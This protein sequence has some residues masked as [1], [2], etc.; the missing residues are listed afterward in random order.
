ML[1]FTNVAF[2][3][4]AR[5]QAFGKPFPDSQRNTTCGAMAN[6]DGAAQP[7][8]YLNYTT[9]D[10]NDDVQPAVSQEAAMHVD[11]D[12]QPVVYQAMALVPAPAPS[13]EEAIPIFDGAAQPAMSQ[14][15]ELVPAQAPPQDQAIPIFEVAFNN[16][17]WWSMPAALSMQLHQSL[18][19]GQNGAYTWGHR[20]YEIDFAA[21]VQTNDANNRQRA[22]R[23]VWLYP[24]E[25]NPDW[26]GQIPQQ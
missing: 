7:V 11:D 17:M 23:L 4:Q 25:N 10:V 8:S 18:H 14:T 9:N 1:L 13:Q 24:Q 20:S 6:V 3:V 16:S 22:I 15:F 26:T 12:E 2:C 21:M 19:A 5:H